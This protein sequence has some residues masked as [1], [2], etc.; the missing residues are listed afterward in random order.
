M[1]TQLNGSLLKGFEILR[2]FS[3]ERPEITANIVQ[4]ELGLNGATAH[5]FLAT[6]EETGAIVPVRRGR[7]RLG[8]ALSDLGR[9]AS[10]TN[11]VLPTMRPLMEAL[12]ASL[13]ESVMLCRLGRTGPTCLIVVEADRPITVGI[14]VGTSLDLLASAQGRIWLADLERSQRQTVVANSMASGGSD[15]LE[16]L[17]DTLAAIRDDGIAVN[18]GDVEPD[19]AAVAVPVRTRTGRLAYTLSVFGPLSR[20]SDTFVTRAATELK[21]TA[22]RIGRLL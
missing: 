4:S 16:A 20:F 3:P 12:T 14:K 11:P 15:T 7:Y 6:L 5:R 22:A 18:R 1:S 17:H 13:S 21:D 2:L 8:Y 9:L 10:E 19:I